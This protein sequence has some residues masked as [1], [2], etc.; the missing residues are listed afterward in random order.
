MRTDFQG[1]SHNHDLDELSMKSVC[2]SHRCVSC[3]YD[4][5]MFLLDEDIERITGLGYDEQFFVEP[6]EGFKVLKNSNAGRCVFHDGTKCTIYENRPK[7]CKLYPIIFDV[8]DKSA[9]KDTFCPYRDEFSVTREAKRELPI[10][11]SQ[12]VA[13]RSGSFKMK[14]K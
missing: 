12:L 6:L 10:V 5:E 14:Q 11:Y 1:K 13:E 7:G 4:T 9:V 8:E 3:C 2:K